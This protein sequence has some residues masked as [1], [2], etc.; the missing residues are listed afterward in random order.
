MTM[1]RFLEFPNKYHEKPRSCKNGKRDAVA[2][3]LSCCCLA[4]DAAASSSN[5]T[6]SHLS[7]HSGVCVCVFVWG[8][9]RCCEARVQFAFH[10]RADK[11]RPTQDVSQHSFL[12][13]IHAG[14]GRL[15][16]IQGGAVHQSVAGCCM[17]FSALQWDYH[18]RC[19]SFNQKNLFN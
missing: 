1:I 4:R 19:M 8:R 16:G 14:Q 15:Q 18:G 2:T 9:C 3:L 11:V 7:L 13:N 12:L 5:L 10:C 17:F 6:C